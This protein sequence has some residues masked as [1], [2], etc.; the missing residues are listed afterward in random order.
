[1]SR[2]EFEFVNTPE[3]EVLRIAARGRDVL[4]NPMTNMGTAFSHEE[5]RALHLTGLLPP[6][7]TTITEQMRRLRLQYDREPD[8]LAKNQFLNGLLNRNEVLFY[9]LFTANLEEMLP[10]VYTPT[11]GEAIKAYSNWYHRPRGIIL[12]IDQPDVMEES[13]QAYGHGP[14]DVDLIVVTDSEG[15]LGIGDQGVGGIKIAVGKLAVYTAAAGIHPRRVLPVVLDVGTD[16]LDLLNQDGYLGLRHAR[17]RGERYDNFIAQ[18]VGAVT[19]LFPNAM[20]HWEDFGAANAHRILAR[21]RDE[22]CTFNDDIQGTAAVVVAAVLASVRAVGQRLSDQRIVIHGA[23]SAGIGIA[24]LMVEL[25]VREGL[26]REQAQSRFW[27]L[28]SRGC[29]REGVPLREFQRPYARSCEELEEWTVSTPGTYDL[30]TVVRNVVPSVLIGTSAQSGAFSEAII[31]EMAEHVERPIIMPLSNPTALAEATPAEI[32]AWTRGRALI[33]TGSPFPPVQLGEVRYTIAQANNALVFP[34]LGLGTIVT[35]ATRVTT[36]MIAAAADAV[37][38]M[39]DPRSP[40]TAVLP[41]MG[42]LRTV[43]ATVGLAVA[44]AAVADGVARVELN[45]PVQQVYQA[46]WQPRYPKVEIAEPG[47][48]TDEGCY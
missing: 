18:F 17:I 35:N 37:A 31:T 15:I 34:G 36:G 46:M 45:N 25:M 28:G 9:R 47:R 39:A 5:R 12:T 16:N 2:A 42:S 33:A 14:E 4:T 6:G 40:G 19:K 48:I 7:V 3:G 27:C 23:G 41:P 13:L 22:I 38:R 1:M 20:L 11:I 29:L 8:D 21:Y 30:A 10:I 44:H 32:L 24:D 26:S 43:S